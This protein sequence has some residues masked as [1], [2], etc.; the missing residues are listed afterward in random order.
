MRKSQTV[1]MLS[2]ETKPSTLDR[3]A[4]KASR[5]ATVADDELKNE[6]EICISPSW[7][8]FG[9]TKKKKEKKQ[10]E[11][12]KK[13]NDKRQK[14]AEE[15]KAAHRLSKKPPAAMDTQKPSAGLRRNSGISFTSSRPSSRGDPRRSWRGERGQSETSD[16]PSGKHRSRSTP[17][18]SDDPSQESP[19]QRGYPV[20]S[21]APQLPKLE[22]SPKLDSFA[23]HTRNSSAGTGQ[24]NSSAGDKAYEK[25]LVD[26]AYR[27][28]ASTTIDPWTPAPPLLKDVP[29]SW[30][31]ETPSFN[32]SQTMPD[33]TGAAKKRM[34]GTK[35]GHRPGSKDDTVGKENPPDGHVGPRVVYRRPLS[36]TQASDGA[37]KFE[38]YGQPWSEESVRLYTAYAP[39]AEQK[40]SLSHAKT[41]KDGSSYVHKQRMHQQQ[42]SIASFQDEQ[43]VKDA[44]ENHGQPPR[45]EDEIADKE[46]PSLG[47]SM[48]V[49]SESSRGPTRQTSLDCECKDEMDCGGDKQPEPKEAPLKDFGDSTIPNPTWAAPASKTDR[50]LN[51]RPF[52]RKSK[53]PNTPTKPA[54]SAPTSKETAGSSPKA[55]KVLRTGFSL[56]KPLKSERASGSAKPAP[57]GM[58]EPVESDAGPPPEMERPIVHTHSRTRTSSSPLMSDETFAN[59]HLRRPSTAPALPQI[60]T[61]ASLA[62]QLTRHEDAAEVLHLA[63]NVSQKETSSSPPSESRPQM[64]APPQGPP[65]VIV[66]GVTGEGLVHQTS[67]KRHRS[68]P[69]LQTIAK[70]SSQLPSLDFLPELKHQPLIKPKRTSPIAPH[71][72]GNPEK[73][74]FGPKAPPLI[75][76]SPLAQSDSLSSLPTKAKEVNMM[77]RSPL[78]L[79]SHHP[80]PEGSLLRPGFNPRRR[81]MSPAINS[82]RPATM[83]PLSFGKGGTAEGLEAKPVA[84]LFVICCK[85]KFWHDL[86]SKLYEL[87]ALPQKLSR[88]DGIENA[89]AALEKTKQA[90]LDTMVKC[91]W[92]EHYMTTWCCAGWTTVVY[93]HERHH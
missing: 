11:R 93:L 68:N 15:I 65:A 49:S 4:S 87:M 7:S 23:W 12:A 22:S 6:L 92:C 85:C 60:E 74:P 89:E 48:T 72:P 37:G 51:F 81:T 20:S 63:G 86:P 66:E 52:Q 62:W 14:K 39:N 42:L 47:T 30:L 73:A 58:T 78:R 13:E 46:G 53:R 83:G 26:F 24:T 69:M 59:K 70:P 71:F 33:L 35:L 84:K 5:A 38:A 27:L 1:P 75:T 19:S 31:P 3:S 18:A 56:P 2:A 64:V 76:S 43:A 61:Q 40:G 41:P 57:A 77:P 10:L 32:R 55:P 67:I 54:V 88:R 28:E 91:P 29:A 34:T 9:T 25:N 21:G 79:E 90:T 50:I 8:E 36:A 82:T 16:K 80:L 44:N 45:E 17:A